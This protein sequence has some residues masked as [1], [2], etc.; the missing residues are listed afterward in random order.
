MT[1]ATEAA[2]AYADILAAGEA[3]T[4]TLVTPGTEDPSTGAFGTPTST[5]VTGAAVEIQGDPKRYLAPGVVVAQAAILLFASPTYGELPDLD[6]QVLWGADLYA[7]K[8][9][10]PL[11]PDGTGI[12]ARVVVTR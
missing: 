2:G 10:K 3:V 1:Y 9:V 6:A 11:R 12:L 8:H 4:F 7:V 5:T